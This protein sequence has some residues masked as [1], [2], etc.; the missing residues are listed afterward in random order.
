[1]AGCA[2]ESTW[3]KPLRLKLRYRSGVAACLPAYLSVCLTC[4]GSLQSSSR[5]GHGPPAASSGLGQGRN[6]GDVKGVKEDEGED[7][8]AG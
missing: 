4:Q 7:R 3:I 2:G 8:T 6:D 5:I 1:M